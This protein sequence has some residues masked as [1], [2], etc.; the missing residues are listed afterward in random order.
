MT[1]TEFNKLV[2]SYETQI[3]HALATGTLHPNADG[4]I[5][6]SILWGRDIVTGKMIR[7]Q[8]E[9]RTAAECAQKLATLHRK[10][11]EGEEADNIPA[12][13]FE[14]IAKEW[15][16][17]EIEYSGISAGNKK[18]YERI[19]RLHILPYFK[20]ADVTQLK[21]KH[22]QMFLNSY[23]G[24][25]VSLV[26]KVRMT[27]MRIIR[28]AMENEYMPERI[29]SL[30]IPDV[31][32][33]ETQEILQREQIKLL[34]QVCKEYHPAFVYVLMVSTGLRP[35]ELFHV[36][37]EDVDFDNKVLYVRKSKT[38]NGI[39]VV[40]LPSYCIEIIREDKKQL[41]QH[42]LH[43]Q[44]VFHQATDPT[45]PHTPTSLNS[46]WKTT[47]RMM[48]ILNGATVYRNKIIISSFTNQEALSPYNLR[49]TYCTMLNDCGIGEYFKKKLMG[50][51]LNDSITD[52]VYTHSNNESILNASAPYLT[53]IEALYTEATT[54][55]SDPVSC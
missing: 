36:Q 16:S 45:I 10:Q 35:C 39:R 53:Y 25:G 17:V 43:P 48:D 41:E 20:T 24:K 11:I 44:Y 30:K 1:P 18:N 37:Y 52:G 29:I 54:E 28:Y 46:N 19:L 7:L 49:H 32:P 27:L 34:F 21:K 50:H 40:P 6:K 3:L 5:K 13:S 8:A 38:K 47:F 22:L 23:A 26:K 42:G 12:R 9:G 4:Y 2:R 31:T 51:S 15:Y 55:K 14:T 33:I